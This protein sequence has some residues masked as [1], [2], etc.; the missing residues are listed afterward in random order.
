VQPEQL[1]ARNHGGVDAAHESTNEEERN[2]LIK[3]KVPIQIYTYLATVADVDLNENDSMDTEDDGSRTEL[4]S[5]AN[6][7]VVGRH[8]YIILDTGRVADVS[9]F[10]PTMHQ[11]SFA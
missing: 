3:I 9:P 6:M 10:T 1:K 5:H 8:A 7:P 4:D 2:K 11:C